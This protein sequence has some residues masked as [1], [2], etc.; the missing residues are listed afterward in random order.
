[1]STIIPLLKDEAT[2]ALDSE[3][4]V[5]V[6]EALDG[7]LRRKEGKMTTLIVA[8]RLSTIQNVDCIIVVC[9]GRIVESGRHEVVRTLVVAPTGTLHL[10]LS[11]FIYL[12]GS[13]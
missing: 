7:I 11:T 2:S 12:L 6:Q 5:V 10:S 4:E 1:M 8:H 3:S 13:S 9:D